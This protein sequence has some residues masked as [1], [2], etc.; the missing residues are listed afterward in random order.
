M[1]MRYATLRYATFRFVSTTDSEYLILATIMA[2]RFISWYLSVKR[3][4][5]LATIGSSS[6]TN[7][8]ASTSKI[9]ILVWSPLTGSGMNLVP[10]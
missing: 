2:R 6:T 9:T 4:D 10:N 3:V 1:K 8:A 5:A 7:Q